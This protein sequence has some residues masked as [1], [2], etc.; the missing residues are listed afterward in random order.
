[1]A[2]NFNARLYAR[3][4]TAAPPPAPVTPA[5][6]VT[7]TQSTC[8]PACVSCGLLECLCRPRFFAGQLLTEQDLN[9]LDAYV[10]AKNRLHT[11][12]LHGWG[13]VNGLMVRCDPCG[14]G[15]VVGTGYAVSPCGEDII[16]CADT[17]VDV[18]ALIKRCTPANVSCQPAASGQTP[19]DCDAL[20][21]D[22]VL[23]IRYTET[24][25]RGVTALRMGATC[26][27]KQTGGT[28]SAAPTGGCGC[29]GA[30]AQTTSTA[31]TYAMTAPVTTPA[32]RT[33]SA[34]CEPTAI[35][36]G[37][38]FDVFPA[39]A[40]PVRGKGDLQIQGPLIQTFLC[41]LEPLIA[42]IPTPPG[43]LNA[44]NFAQQPAAWNL[45]CCRTKQALINYFS[46]GPQPD[47]TLLAR[48]QTWSCPD[49]SNQAFAQQMVLAYEVL[50]VL[51]LDAMLACLCAALL[52]PAPFGTS[53]DRVPLALV[54]V[55]KKT[56][57]VVEVCNWT[58]LRK[59]MITWPAIE[60]WLSWVPWL[61]SFP[62]IIGALCCR[63]LTLPTGE[64]RDNGFTVAGAPAAAA[65]TEQA[66][67]SSYSSDPAVL[68]VNPT[69]DADRVT[70]N[71]TLTRLIVD[72][73]AR[74][75]APIDP[76]AVAGG[77]FGFDTGAK[78][79][80]DAAETANLA[81]FLLINQVLRPVA[82]SLAP[83]AMSRSVLGAV[84]SV[85][86][87]GDDYAALKNR[88]TSLEA[89]LKD[90]QNRKGPVEETKHETPKPTE[91][92]ERQEKPERPPRHRKK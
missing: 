5:A 68:E 3:A 57:Q 81:P 84:E 92:A 79:P 38:S 71:Q 30:T 67:A 25:T 75:R 83:A 77:V 12:Q 88:V 63:E 21:E 24:P 43:P 80:L 26:S 37:Y 66:T 19:Q 72:A 48:L 90:L 10:R 73:L 60:Y 7:T 27:C 18:C 41:C 17:S 16:V 44:G 70:D 78:Q 52:P 74:A 1:M 33:T 28:C 85:L 11:L 91:A 51:L 55:V 65:K 89:A 20:I 50:L 13:V 49:P 40:T 45:W 22:W 36:E 4:R 35:C 32:A 47:C 8:A 23:A 82:S 9:R 42:A 46:S 6:G 76:K 64:T 15:V 54:R 59:Q 14:T 61:A 29:G 86:G 39:P 31:P 56:C 34:Q 53:D 69:L 2:D 87:G 62:D 58:S